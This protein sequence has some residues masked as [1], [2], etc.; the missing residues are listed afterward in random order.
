MTDEPTKTKVRARPPSRRKPV[1]WLTMLVG[2][3]VILVS[4]T[5]VADVILAYTANDSIGPNIASPFLFQ[6]GGN[7]ASASSLGVATDAFPAAGNSGVTVTTTLA[8]IQS[9]PVG[10]LDI[11]EF[12]VGAS[13]TPASATVKT[14]YVPSPSAVAIAGVV[15]A[16]AFISNGA[17]AF[18]VAAVA[19]APAGCGATMPTVASVSAGCGVVA[20]AVT[21][22]N[23][24][25]GVV[26]GALSCAVASATAASS[27]LLYVSYWITTNGAVTGTTSVNSFVIP[28]SMP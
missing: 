3:G 4:G 8:G 26:A 12:A 2:V 17:P 24:M 1:R 16:Y 19:G 20:T 28:I 7:Y 6:K 25:S 5:V 11:N 21:V 13:A 23:L 14:P 27:V 15:C 22:V 9:V 10:L 18:G